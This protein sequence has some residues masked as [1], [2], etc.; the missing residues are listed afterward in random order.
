[1]WGIIGNSSFFVFFKGCL[2]GFLCVSASVVLLE[3]RR[4]IGTL[5]KEKLSFQQRWTPSLIFI[6]TSCDENASFESLP[7]LL[8]CL[9]A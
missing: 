8:E 4:K 6:K 9:V 1:M 3:T 7:G 5:T 2:K